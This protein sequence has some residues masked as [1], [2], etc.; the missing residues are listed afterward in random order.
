MRLVACVD[1]LDDDDFLAGV[2][3]SGDDG[4]AADFE[5]CRRVLV[6]I[7]IGGTADAGRTLHLGEIVSGRKG[8]RS[9]GR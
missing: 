5:D 3:A 9:R 8:K 1:G 2:A 6:E 4:Y 7:V